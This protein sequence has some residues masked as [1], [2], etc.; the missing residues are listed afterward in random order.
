MRQ[1]K[2]DDFILIK[3]IAHQEEITILNMCSPNTGSSNVMKQM[4]LDLKVTE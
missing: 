2:E 3:E 4:L 1:D